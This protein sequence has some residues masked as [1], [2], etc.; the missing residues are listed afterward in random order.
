M[1]RTAILCA[2]CL[3][4]LLFAA[5]CGKKEF[6]R[7]SDVIL[8]DLVSAY[9]RSARAAAESESSENS[10]TETAEESSRAADEPYEPD[11]SQDPVIE[12]II[13]AYASSGDSRVGQLLAELKDADSDLGERWEDILDYWKFVNNQM[14]INENKLPENL[15]RDDSLCIV[16]LGYELNPDGSMPPELIG[17]LETALACAKQ[18]PRAYILCTGGKTAVSNPKVSEGGKMRDWLKA[19]GVKASRIITERKSL[20]TAENAENSYAILRSRY[21]QVKSVAIVSSNYH[22][23]WGALMFETVFRTKSAD[24]AQGDIHVLSNCAYDVQYAGYGKGD[25]LLFQTG[26]MLELLQHT[27]AD[28]A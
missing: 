4:L 25:L 7:S 12:N 24:A 21:P 5:G 19:H 6:K 22:I 16:V 3:L 2:V 8:R 13:N 17:R 15:P 18:Y 28:E 20:S 10:E 27:A 1:K 9:G 23:P 11:H 14:P 26:G